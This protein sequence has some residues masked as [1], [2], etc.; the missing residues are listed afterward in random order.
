MSKERPLG[1]TEWHTVEALEKIIAERTQLRQHLAASDALLE[2]AARERSAWELRSTEFE[3]KA[4]ELECALEASRA[5]TREARLVVDANYREIDR[6]KAEVS[7]GILASQANA[8]DAR[9]AE[10]E[11]ERLKGELASW[12]DRHAAAQ[13]RASDAGDALSAAGLRAETAEGLLRRYR[14]LDN[15][16][17]PNVI[18]VTAD[19]LGDD[20]DAFLAP[21]SD[22]PVCDTPGCGRTIPEG[23]EGHPEICPTCLACLKFHGELAGLGGSPAVV[24]PPAPGVPETLSPTEPA[25]TPTEKGGAR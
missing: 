19:Q 15:E 6:L 12:Y 7:A 11:A 24:P 9:A 3:A 18:A 14:Q 16:T 10:D 1:I 5:E 4:H 21:T 25:A 23:G 22:R 13:F 2:K 17:S 8:R 20:T